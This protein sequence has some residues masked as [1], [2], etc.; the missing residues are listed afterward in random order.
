MHIQC[1]GNQFIEQ[2]AR[3]N[4]GILD[5]FTDRYLETGVCLSACWIATTVLVRFEGSAQWRNIAVE[6]VITCKPNCVQKEENLELA[7]V[8][9]TWR[10]HLLCQINGLPFRSIILFLLSVFSFCCICQSAYVSIRQ[11][12]L[13]LYFSPS[14]CPIF[15][16]TFV[17][18]F[19]FLLSKTA[20]SASDTDC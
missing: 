11:S 8:A 12:S 1:R 5:V 7:H 18:P 9:V 2:L 4:P 10:L 6:P 15:L 16:P 20:F 19:S 3:D 17:L 14:F 13:F